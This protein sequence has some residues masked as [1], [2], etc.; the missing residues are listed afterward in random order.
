MSESDT[1]G[2]N[3]PSAWR[4][5]VSKEERNALEQELHRELSRRHSLYGSR[6]TAIARRDDDDDVLFEVTG[7]KHGFA[8][9]HLT[10]SGGQEANPVFPYTRWYQTLSEWIAELTNA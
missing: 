8:V 1:I 5:V 2:D 4:L 7:D 10:W 3:S 9:V 6:A